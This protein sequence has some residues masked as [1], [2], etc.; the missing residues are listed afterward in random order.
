MY[1]TLQLSTGLIT[2]N[3]RILTSI[4]FIKKHIYTDTKAIKNAELIKAW[5]ELEQFIVLELIKKCTAFHRNYLQF[6]S[7]DLNSCVTNVLS[8]SITTSVHSILSMGSSVPCILSSV[9]V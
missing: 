9:L 8:V 6:L 2:L 7:F 3:T 1:K 4:K 5:V